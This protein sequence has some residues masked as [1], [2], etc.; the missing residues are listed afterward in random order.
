MSDLWASPREVLN[1]Y[2]VFKYPDFLNI[3]I[4]DDNNLY[5][6]KWS[7]TSARCT[8]TSPGS[9]EIEGKNGLLFW[10]AGSAIKWGDGYKLKVTEIPK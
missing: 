8:A 5:I 7:G 2:N 6:G 10:Y 3:P 1:A 9:I 4:Y